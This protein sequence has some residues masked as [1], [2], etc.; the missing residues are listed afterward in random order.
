MR[1]PLATLGLVPGPAM[2]VLA[3]YRRAHDGDSYSLLIDTSGDPTPSFD[4]GA[5]TRWI[6]LRDYSAIEL[7]KPADAE[8]VS[9][10]VARGIANDVLR[11]AKEILVELKGSYSFRRHVAWVWVDGRSLGEVLLER[12]AV[13][14]GRR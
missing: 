8:R 1:D 9:G 11:N 6:R 7:G 14:P 4:E 2:S 10:D 5:E 13:R 12:R 3:E